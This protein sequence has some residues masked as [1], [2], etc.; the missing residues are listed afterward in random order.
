MKKKLFLLALMV[1]LFACVL[2]ISVSAKDIATGYYDSNGNEIVVPTYDENGEALLWMRRDKSKG[3]PT[4]QAIMYYECTDEDGTEYYLFSRKTNDSI[5]VS[6]N[7]SFS[8][9]SNIGITTGNVVIMNLDGIAHSDGTGVQ[10]FAFTMQNNTS[11][12]YVFFPASLTSTKNINDNKQVFLGNSALEVVEFAPGS[13]ITEL[14]PS[15]F[16]SCAITEIV[17]PEGLTFI[18]ERAFDACT[19]LKKIY[20]PRTV[21]FID[22]IA[23]RGVT[24]AEYYFTGVEETTSGWEITDEIT[25][26]NHCDVYYGGEHACEDDG[27]CT[28]PLICDTCGKV[29]EAD[30]SIHKL[31]VEVKYDN[32]YANEGYKRNA[33]TICNSFVASEEKLAPIFTCLGYSTSEDNSGIATGFVV[34]QDSLQEYESTGKK[35]T[36]GVVVFNPKYLNSD[37]VFTAD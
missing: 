28:T 32:G 37:T 4:T 16:K 27:D 36:F 23:F 9:K 11:L 22:E 10:R 7:Y 5:S 17:L 33:C 6:S 35:I 21:T 24:N 26:V 8:F 3:A 2:V 31:Q 12:Q 15:A 1:A 13:Q 14:G 19:S 34:N 29:F 25:Y 20:I 18:D 30:I